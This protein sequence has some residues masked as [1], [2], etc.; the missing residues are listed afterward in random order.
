MI[1][2]FTNSYQFSIRL[3]YQIKVLDNVNETKLFGT[4]ISSDLKWDKNTDNIVKKA[5]AKMEL[6]RKMSVI[7][8]P[9]SDLKKKII[10]HI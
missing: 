6:L 3:K 7:G 5:Y 1:F 4:V 10:L 8:A 2:N 9:I